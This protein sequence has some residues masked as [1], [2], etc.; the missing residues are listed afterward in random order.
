MIIILIRELWHNENYNL[1]DRIFRLKALNFNSFSYY[2][3]LKLGNTI[4]LLIRK[5]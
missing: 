5:I 2:E 3:V 4:G 1:I